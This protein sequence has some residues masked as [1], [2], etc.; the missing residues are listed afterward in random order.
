VQFGASVTKSKWSL[1]LTV[2]EQKDNNPKKL[3]S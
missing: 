3:S 2:S 1:L